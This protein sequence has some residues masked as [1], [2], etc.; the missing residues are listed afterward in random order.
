MLG[1]PNWGEGLVPVLDLG[2][3]VGREVTVARGVGFE[4][5]VAIP[6]AWL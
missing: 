4:V 2:V 3:G 5:G 6:M 1:V